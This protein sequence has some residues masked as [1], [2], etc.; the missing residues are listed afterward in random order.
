MFNTVCLY[1]DENTRRV[2][3]CVAF[4]ENVAST[5]F[6]PAK[7]PQFQTKYHII[8][9]EDML[10]KFYLY[11]YDIMY[12]VRKHDQEITDQYL[13]DISIL[14]K[15]FQCIEFL[16]RTMMA[17]IKT[18]MGD[19]FHCEL[20]YSL[21]KY[22]MDNNLCTDKDS[23]SQFIMSQDNLTEDIFKSLYN[24]KKQFI[25]EKQKDIY[26]SMI[27]GQQ[28]IF[29]SVNPEKETMLEMFRTYYLK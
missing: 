25:Y 4:K 28:N 6:I 7:I 20:S 1:V 12:G 18:S 2:V 21:I 19:T 9:D 22:E 26:K 23:L 14:N 24:L 15:K 11:E 16:F 27:V 5:D 10:E 3:R 17:F 29:N 8:R 13:N